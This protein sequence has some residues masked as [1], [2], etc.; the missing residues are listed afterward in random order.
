[1]E[2]IAYS[3]ADW[4]WNKQDRKIT[5]G[6]LFKFLNAPISWCAK[7]QPVVTLS[8]CESEYIAGC[9]AASQVV[10]LETILKEME[11][12]VR[13]PIALFIDNKSAINLAKN[14]V[15]HGRRKHIEAKF[16]FLRQQVNK[17]ALKIVY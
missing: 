15:L 12:E 10:W 6:Y 4:C 13:I 3:D 5:S 9:M 17:E 1:M 2:L 16:H 7:K 8:T 14:L 11:I